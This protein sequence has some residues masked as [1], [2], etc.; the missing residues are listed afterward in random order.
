MEKLKVAA[1]LDPAFAPIYREM[2]AFAARA[3][4]GR[5]SALPWS[6]TTAW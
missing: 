4:K 1:P 6:E 5:R 2:Q 3:A